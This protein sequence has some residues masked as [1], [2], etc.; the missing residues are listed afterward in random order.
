MAQLR[1]KVQ[2]DEY[3]TIKDEIIAVSEQRYE[4]ILTKRLSEF[5]KELMGE[6]DKRF[7]E[8]DKKFHVVYWIFGIFITLYLATYTILLNL[9]LNLRK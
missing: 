7:E 5:K 3:K 1:R 9:V 8:V 6:A 4:N 2:F